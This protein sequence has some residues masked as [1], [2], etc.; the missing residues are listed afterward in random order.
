MENQSNM[1]D[2]GEERGLDIFI[3]K[4]HEIQGSIG[5]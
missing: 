5:K 3:Y 2:G 1:A 4:K